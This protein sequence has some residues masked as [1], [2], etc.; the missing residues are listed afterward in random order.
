MS[1]YEA[2][3]GRYDALTADVH[4][5]VWADYAEKHFRR[6]GLPVHTVLDLACG[7]GSCAAAVC[8]SMAGFT[9]R[10]VKVHLALG[11]L[12][13]EWAENGHIYMT[14]PAEEIFEGNIK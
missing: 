6:A 1:S 8:A 7:T 12:L 4:Y 3:A 9:G 13:I 2:L 14:G 11:E 5:E 10:S